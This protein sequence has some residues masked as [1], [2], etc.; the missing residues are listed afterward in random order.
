M[1]RALETGDTTMVKAIIR[2]AHSRGWAE[3]AMAG[4][5]RELLIEVSRLEELTSPRGR[6]TSTRR[7]FR[8][9]V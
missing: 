8:W 7:M 3:V 6:G 9:S 5:D 4:V 2:R 1:S